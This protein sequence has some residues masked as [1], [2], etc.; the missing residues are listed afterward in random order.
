MKRSDVAVQP[1]TPARGAPRD[2]TGKHLHNEETRPVSP[3]RSLKRDMSRGYGLDDEGN[4]TQGTLLREKADKDALEPIGAQPDDPD[5]R[6]C[7]ASRNGFNTRESFNDFQAILALIQDW[8]VMPHD[9][10]QE[11]EIDRGSFGSIFTGTF[12]DKPV[13]VKHVGSAST[14]SGMSYP[15]VCRAVRQELF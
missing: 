15:Q 7:W 4:S 9:L 8:Y 14:G 5:P 6:I 13:A 11:G 2:F 12:L 3:A 1:E 10:R